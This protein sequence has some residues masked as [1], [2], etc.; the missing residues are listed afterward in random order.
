MFYDISTK[1]LWYVLAKELDLAI[2]TFVLTL[3]GSLL[4]VNYL[5]IEF[6]FS[7]ILDC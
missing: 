7:V 5:V 3:P 2:K 1:M 4:V 6:Y